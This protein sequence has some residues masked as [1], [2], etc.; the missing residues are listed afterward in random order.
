MFNLLRKVVGYKTTES[1]TTVPHVTFIYEADATEMLEA[2][3][4]LCPRML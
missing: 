4:Q 2:W 3:I 1:W